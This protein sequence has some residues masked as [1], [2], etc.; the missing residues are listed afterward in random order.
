MSLKEQ[1]YSVLIVSASEK[2]KNA[3]TSLLPEKTYAPVHTVQ[4]ISSAQRLIS[5][6][7]Y[8]LVLI[9]A[10]L[11]D[12]FG[13]KFAIDL[14]APGSTIA[15]VFVRR[16]LYEEIR[17]KVL[18]YG[19]LVLSKPTSLS[20]LSQSLDWMKAMK[21]RL[22]KYEKKTVS[23]EE[24]MADIRII[25]RA[26]WAL[27]ESCSMT[28]ADAHRYIEKQ[29]MDRCITKREIADSILKTYH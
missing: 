24:K 28:E 3:L 12:D 14:S 21:E 13:E 25:N 7:S 20:I 23:L 16:E 10:P 2:I 1:I 11:P 27:I 29:A 22:R 4:S 9:D 6:R 15:V 17:A 19:V 26:K 8:D 5:Q 18:P